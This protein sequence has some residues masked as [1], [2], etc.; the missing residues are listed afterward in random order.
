MH[1]T[2]VAS[3]SGAVSTTLQPTS[4]LGAC[5]PLRPGATV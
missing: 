4:A 3:L 1:L 2:P 5:Q